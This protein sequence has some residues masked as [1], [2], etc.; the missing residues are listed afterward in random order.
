VFTE[1]QKAVTLSGA[2]GTELK[3]ER[4]QPLLHDPRTPHPTYFEREAHLPAMKNSYVYILSNHARMLY[5]GITSDLRRRVYEH[6]RK[7]LPGYTA[8]R[9]IDRLVYYEHTSDVRFA[10][11]REKQLKGWRRIRKVELVRAMNPA[12]RDLS[13]SLWPGLAEQDVERDGAGDT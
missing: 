13:E 1:P 6:K 8:E 11:A 7:L 12:W 5:I 3:N 2:K 10:I 9:E 4:H